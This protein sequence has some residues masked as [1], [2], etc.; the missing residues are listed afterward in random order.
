MSMRGFVVVGAMKVNGTS[1]VGNDAADMG[2]SSIPW[3]HNKIMDSGIGR[4]PISPGNGFAI[5]AKPATLEPMKP[6]G[7]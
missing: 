6:L 3:I 4:K 2:G 5:F 7:R 1:I